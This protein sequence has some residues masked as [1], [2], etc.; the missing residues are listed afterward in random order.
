[1]SAGQQ[2]TVESPAPGPQHYQVLCGIALAAVF[3]ILMQQQVPLAGV[4]ALLLGAAGILLRARI[5]PILVLLA[6]V[7][8]QLY[9]QYLFSVWRQHGALDVEDVVLCAATLA[10]VAG[11]YRLLAIW[12]HIL[13]PDPRQRYHKQARAVV[14]VGR[15]GKIAPQHRPVALVSRSE[16]ALFV[17][18]L[19]LFALLAQGAWMVI[20]ARR[21][22]HE[23]SP[24][25]MQLLQL[26]W[27]VA[28]AAFVIG[29]FFR[30]WRL[31]SMDRLTAQML[32]QDALWH[33]T[34]GEQRRIGRWLAW[35]NLRRRT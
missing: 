33:E 18:Q 21:E 8:G 28:L 25:W 16:L 20:G 10:Y 26:T 22:L 31:L 29:Q 12:R 4:A 35:F 5:S 9:R 30:I 23:L 24:R 11:H 2:S 19:P 6:V 34:R 14:P 17:L 15:I 27:G 1:M 13:P 32:L 7:G 3:L